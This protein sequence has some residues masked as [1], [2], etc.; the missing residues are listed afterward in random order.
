MSE[1]TIYERYRLGQAYMAD[2][3][4]RSAARV[5]EPAVEAEPTS[6]A[7]WFL[8]AQAYF[9][10]AR[11]RRAEAAFQRVV[12][13]DPTD[14][15]ARFGLGRALERQSR[16]GEALAQYRIALALSP[17]ADYLEARQRV[18]ARLAA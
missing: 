6:A 4:V 13:I 3:D 1:I 15:H 18:E 10:A 17:E 14:H 5:L 7:L 11:L 9:G 12:E 16:Y 2:G 8:L